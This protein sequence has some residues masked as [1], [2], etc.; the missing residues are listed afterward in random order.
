MNF[1]EKK[2]NSTRN[3]F[4]KWNRFAGIGQRQLGAQETRRRN[5]MFE[6]DC[7]SVRVNNPI[8][9]PLCHRIFLVFSSP[10]ILSVFCCCSSSR[11]SNPTHSCKQFIPMRF[12]YI[13]P[14]T[15][16]LSCSRAEYFIS[17]YL[18]R[19]NR[20]ISPDCHV[21]WLLSFSVRSPLLL[22]VR[23]AFKCRMENVISSDT[24][25]RD[26]PNISNSKS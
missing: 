10:P 18:I 14:E 16:Y 2:V 9:L 12:R 11:S 24:E 5:K 6:S 15:F 22:M 8:R 25:E 21:G 7:C 19:R 1:V 23:A 4:R 17:F 3:G 13:A 26:E 20:Y